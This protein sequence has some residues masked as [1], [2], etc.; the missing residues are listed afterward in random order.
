MADYLY[1]CNP[2]CR[3]RPRQGDY[4]SGV[5]LSDEFETPKTSALDP[6]GDEASVDPFADQSQPDSLYSWIMGGDGSVPPLSWD[7]DVQYS[8][9]PLGADTAPTDGYLF[10]PSQDADDAHYTH[11]NPLMGSAGPGTAAGSGMAESSDPSFGASARP[12][13][14]LL[15]QIGTARASSDAQQQQQQ[16][17]RPSK[18]GP[19]EQEWEE[20]QPLI[21]FL[22]APD[23]PNLN[24][25]LQELMK[26]MEKV[27]FLKG[28]ASHVAIDT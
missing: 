15:S 26:V 28:Y 11:S 4:D 27:G 3:K 8:D 10:G 19:S 18:E 16:Q 7:I 1:P 5:L 20:R 25:T 21:Q 13:D 24:L 14:I 2:R 12:G 22:Y 9:D 17:Q 6:Y 23:K